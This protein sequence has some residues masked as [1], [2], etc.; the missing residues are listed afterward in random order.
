MASKSHCA[1]CPP[2][3]DAARKTE[4]GR[5]WLTGG[6]PKDNNECLSDH[7][8]LL[9][10]PRTT[11]QKASKKTRGNA[12]GNATTLE[13]PCGNLTP[14]PMMAAIARIRGTRAGSNKCGIVVQPED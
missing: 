11:C 12:A 13:D 1:T 14:L 6:M 7:V 10:T 9:R 5:L 8:A 4:K 2:A 3:C